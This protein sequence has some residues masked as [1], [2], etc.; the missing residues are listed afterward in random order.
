M[1]KISSMKK[2]EGIIF[3]IVLVL[4]IAL[5]YVS[6]LQ[7]AIP[8]TLGWWNYYGWRL[9][10]GDVLYQDLFCY[11][12]PYMPMLH[13]FLY[14]FFSNNILQY[15]ILGVLIVIFTS[16]FV[17]SVLLKYVNPMYSFFS[18]ITG[19][20]VAQ[21][22]LA[23]LP[24]DYNPILLFFTTMMAYSIINLK[25]KKYF[26]AILCGLS[27]GCLLMIKQTMLVVIVMV[28]GIHIFLHYKDIKRQRIVYVIIGICSIIS[29][30]PAF[31]YLIS[32]DS[33]VLAVEQIVHGSSAKG[34]S[35]N[36][37][38]ALEIIISRYL[39]NGFSISNFCIGILLCIKLRIYTK[40]DNFIN[41]VLI[42]LILFKFI[43]LFVIC[44][45][46]S[47]GIIPLVTGIVIMVLVL[48]GIISYF[49]LK[50]ISQV[51]I[52]LD[53]QEQKKRNYLYCLIGVFIFI[54]LLS[55]YTCFEQRLQLY[56]WGNGQLFF[57][58]K[59]SLSEVAFYFV[60][61]IGVD[62][63]AR[64]NIDNERKGIVEFFVYMFV[65]QAMILVGSGS[66]D[67]AFSMP[68]VAFMIAILLKVLRDISLSKCFLYGICIVILISSITQKQVVPYSW[69]GWES[70]GLSDSELTFLYSK[71]KPLDGYKLDVDAETAYENV[72]DAILTYT[73]ADD[74]VYEYPHSP[75]FNCIT[76]RKLGTFAVSHFTDVCPDDI[77]LR[78]LELIKEKHPSMFIYVKLDE[79]AW[80]INEKYYRNGRFSARKEVEKFYNQVIEKTYTLVYKYK[81]I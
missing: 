45:D 76:E 40:Y 20:F 48:E 55:I 5:F 9:Y 15:Q 60:A 61:A 19:I 42:N 7:Y 10:S 73:S 63:C 65:F 27:I 26:F 29:M 50:H 72:V 74:I 12:P 31:Y 39:T 54:E 22:F 25:T 70:Q 59:R 24:F 77:L 78:D 33:L 80:W 58:F 52:N 38:D 37:F 81:N 51:I 71:I 4:G 21:G 75:L 14:S 49:C 69:H 79:G 23:H 68:T 64:N 34:V 43:R 30:F 56:M 13:A 17:Y 32:T 66:L 1:L 67:E 44:S 2:H 28:C 41:Y 16:L 8:P 11:L 3:G 47:V 35:S 53:E 62:V 6:F 36:I 18:V 57:L 46:Y